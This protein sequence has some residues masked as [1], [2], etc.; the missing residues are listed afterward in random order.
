MGFKSYPLVCSTVAGTAKTNWM[1][2]S[3]Q[4]FPLKLA[5]GSLRMFHIAM[6]NVTMNDTWKMNHTI[7]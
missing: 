2:T 1:P 4:F 3:V 7:L 6:E 5:S